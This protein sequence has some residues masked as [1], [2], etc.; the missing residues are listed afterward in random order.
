M[1]DPIKALYLAVIL[2]LQVWPTENKG[3]VGE[4]IVTPAETAKTL[5]QFYK[6]G[7]AADVRNA[8]GLLISAGLAVDN[9]DGTFTV[10]KPPRSRGE[11]DLARIIANRS[12]DQSKPI[13]RAPR[14]AAANP[15]NQLTLFD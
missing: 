11:H 2:Y 4:V 7:S 8:M 12:A 14:S 15:S 6:A 10:A 13:V 3:K 1:N 5:R 9:K